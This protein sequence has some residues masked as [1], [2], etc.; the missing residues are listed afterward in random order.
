MNS[1]PA[2][3][4]QSCGS[5]ELSHKQTMVSHAPW[6][7][8]VVLCGDLKSEYYGGGNMGTLAGQQMLLKIDDVHTPQPMSH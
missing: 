7:G 6:E 3:A 2:A 5:E 1:K 8:L 4:V